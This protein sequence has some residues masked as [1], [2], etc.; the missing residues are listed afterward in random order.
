MEDNKEGRILFKEI[1]FCYII[2]NI[3][4]LEWPPNSLSF[5]WCWWRWSHRQGW[6]GVSSRIVTTVRWWRWAHGSSRSKVVMGG[7]RCNRHLLLCLSSCFHA[8]DAGSKMTHE[9][10]THDNINV[11]DEKVGVTGYTH[12]P[13]DG[14]T[15]PKRKEACLVPWYRERPI[16][17]RFSG[18]KSCA[19]W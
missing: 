16:R 14:I 11:V 18:R 19:I 3:F 4:F 6:V 10:G 17:C 8:A 13:K 5:W 12:E 1:T 15:K 7:G 9:S 2:Q